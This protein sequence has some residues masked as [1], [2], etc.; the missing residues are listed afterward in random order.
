MRRKGKN[1]QIQLPQTKKLLHRKEANYRM[2][3]K[4]LET[5]HP[6]RGY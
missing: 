5:V 4:Y 3:K 2:G 1:R 6:A